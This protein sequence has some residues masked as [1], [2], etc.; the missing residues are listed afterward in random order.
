MFIRKHFS[1]FV[2]FNANLGEVNQLENKVLEKGVKKANMC[3]QTHS[4]FHL[5]SSLTLSYEMIAKKEKLVM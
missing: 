1:V 4:H 5:P 3:E 2:I